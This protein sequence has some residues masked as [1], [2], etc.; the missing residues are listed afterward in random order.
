[1]MQNTITGKI[2]FPILGTLLLLLWAFLSANAQSML[3][4]DPQARA[5]Q[6]TE[7]MKK[8]LKL[9][10]E[11]LSKIE[12]INLKYTQQVAEVIQQSNGS[13]MQAMGRVG[14]IQSAK[15]KEIKPILDK[16]QWKKYRKL[17]NKIRS[18]RP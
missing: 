17:Q 11:Q 15:E 1:M 4:I 18:Q 10:D 8:E 9:S 5:Q 13:Y 6:E 7:T 14:T 3:K 2:I 12:P 16:N